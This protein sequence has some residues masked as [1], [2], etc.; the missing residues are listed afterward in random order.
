MEIGNE[1]RISTTPRCR[2][3]V[4]TLF[5]DAQRCSRSR[6]AS[7]HAR[8]VRP[9]EMGGGRKRPRRT[10]VLRSIVSIATCAG[11]LV[12]ADEPPVHNHCFPCRPE[13]AAGTSTR[14][15]RLSRGRGYRIDDTLRVWIVF[16]NGCLSPSAGQV[17]SSS[18]PR[19]SSAAAVCC[20]CPAIPRFQTKADRSRA[21]AD[22]FER[23]RAVVCA[24]AAVRR[25]HAVSAER[26]PGPTEISRSS[27]DFVANAITE[28]AASRERHRD[29][30]DRRARFRGSA[31]TAVC[32]LLYKSRNQSLP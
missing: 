7:M 10:D 24:T 14:C 3:G 9:R 32:S 21:V 18:F 20:V 8:A 28:A 15:D 13:R 2:Q 22:R 16:L 19:L 6:R 30:A 11:A 31:G 1:G 23:D 27:R 26:I 29:E 5:E 12:K 17:R 25:R 4:D